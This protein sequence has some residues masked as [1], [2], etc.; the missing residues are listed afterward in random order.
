MTQT[1]PAHGAAQFG[2][3]LG[4]ALRDVREGRGLTRAQIQAAS[5]LARSTIARIELGERAADMEQL[6]RYVMAVNALQDPD[7]PPV[8][9][10]AVV[11]RAEAALAARR[12][13]SVTESTASVDLD[14]LRPGAGRRTPRAPG[15]S[16]RT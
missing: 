9:I 7:I 14:T 6:A 15:G 11:A 3:A 5:G 16:D 4:L 12:T 13:V 10:S 8:T 2:P 1:T